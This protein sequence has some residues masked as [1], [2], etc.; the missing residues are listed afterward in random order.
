MKIYS[1]VEYIK[2]FFNG[3]SA[4]PLATTSVSDAEL[5]ANLCFD[6][7][8]LRAHN[9]LPYFYCFMNRGE[10]IDVCEYLLRR[11]GFLPRQHVSRYMGWQSRALRIP[12]SSFA[13]ND[14]KMKFLKSVRVNFTKRL[15][16]DYTQQVAQIR[17]EMA[18]K[19]K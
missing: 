6:A 9:G 5:L 11:N 4:R 12:E 1:C 18:Q 2:D 14:A 8:F 7:G 16:H 13:D 10:D 3:T 17:A 19:T 15:N